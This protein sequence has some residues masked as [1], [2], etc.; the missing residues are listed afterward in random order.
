MIINKT[1]DKSLWLMLCSDKLN[2]KKIVDFINS[3][4]SELYNKL[5]V[6][7]G[8]Y[9]DK[10]RNFSITK[11]DELYKSFL[12]S[13]VRTTGDMRYW[14]TFDT[15]TG[16]LNFGESIICDGE[17][18][19]TF[20]MTIYPLNDDMLND[21]KEYNDCLVGE[22]TNSYLDNYENE[23]VYFHLIRFS[24]CDII[25]SSSRDKYN[26]NKY[27]LIDMDNM[28]NNYTLSNLNNECNVKKLIRGKQK[29][30]R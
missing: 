26:K 12:S 8:F 27:R 18:Y 29:N 16:A 25:V 20:C 6:S 23:I 5:R 2:R 4:P 9:V 17:E 7:L 14:Y 3:I 11:N 21:K 15:K 1:Y 22:I 28:P 24:F 30:S 19:N 10:K 13:E